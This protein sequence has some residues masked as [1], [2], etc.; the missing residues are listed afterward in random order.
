[1]KPIIIAWIVIIPLLLLLGMTSSQKNLL[2]NGNF[3][4][5]TGSEPN[6]WSSSNIPKILTVVSPSTKCHS[7]KYAV[8]FE[9]KDFY[10]SKFA[11]MI[12][13]KNV[14]ISGTAL[15]LSGYYV[16]NSIGKDVGFISLE[17]Q[18]DEGSTV[19]VC[20]E[21][22]VNPTV[23]FTRFTVTGNI[24][25]GAIRLEIKLTLLPGQGSGK[26]HEG[27][28]ILFDDLELVPVSVEGQEKQ[29]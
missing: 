24:P 7:G 8:M 13:Q 15:Q 4:S 18:N 9:V 1:M 10:G 22:L 27:S 28:Y 25:R 19:N 11:G 2:K 6:G 5:F 23:G 26:C 17:L 3:E 16:L 14:E 21:N 20:Q 12:T 29:Q